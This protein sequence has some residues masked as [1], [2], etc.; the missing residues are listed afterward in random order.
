MRGILFLAIL[1]L[2]SGISMGLDKGR[3]SD[4]VDDFDKEGSDNEDG[5]SSDEVPDKRN[6]A[7]TSIGEVVKANRAAANGT[8]IANDAAS[9]GG[10]IADV[11][12]GKSA[13][14]MPPTTMKATTTTKKKKTKP[15]T[16]I[17]VIKKPEPKLE[18]TLILGIKWWQFLC[19][20]LGSVL[21]LMF[22]CVCCCAILDSTQRH[23]VRGN[24]GQR[25]GFF[26]APGRHIILVMDNSL[27]RI[28]GNNGGA[29]TATPQAQTIQPTAATANGNPP[30]APTV[31]PAVYP[32][33]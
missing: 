18:D 24:N 19:I 25:L 20:V 26:Q 6:M 4:A 14:A 10:T 15:K 27:G 1:S 31:Q 22:L 23:E 16:N 21:A 8:K 17:I 7:E 33:L 30:H 29:S 13:V 3:P 32:K 12:Q 5:I 11:R 9:D 2:L 28:R